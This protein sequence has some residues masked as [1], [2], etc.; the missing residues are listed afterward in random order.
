MKLKTIT[1]LTLA[2]LTANVFA[3]EADKN[4]AKTTLDFRL[5]YENVGQDNPLEDASALTLRTLLNYTS[6]SYS[7]FSGFIEFED[8]R[9]VAGIDDYNDGNGSK[10]DYSVVADP[11]TTELDQGYVK[12]AGSGLTAKVGRQVITFDNHRFVGH[13]GWRQDKQTFDGAT[14]NYKLGKD[15][16]LN[17]A[18]VTQRNRIFGEEKDLKSKDHMLNAS[19]NLGFAKLTGY[20][21]L[22]EV[23]NNTDNSL[24]TFGVR[25]AGS[26][27]VSKLKVS[28]QAEFA[29]QT[30]D[31]AGVEF[32]APYYLLE[33]GAGF[34]GIMAKLG[35]ESLGSDDGLYGFSTPL[36]TLHKF[37]GWSDQ[38]LNTPVQGLNDLYVSLSGKLFEGNW[39][40]IYH[41]FTAAEST[42]LVDDLGNEINAQYTQKFGGRYS[43]GLKFA[44]YSAGDAGAGKV[45]TDKVW[46]WM[47]ARF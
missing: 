38:F 44:M 34:S 7:G 21:Y 15:L 4:E 27:D 41:N 18:Y 35:Y 17:Y 6:K 31:T 32:T 13:V 45:D 43:A 24:N 42:A 29:T 39:A 12:W 1:L 3:E 33:A 47:T 10:P 36:A 25:L 20:G 28:Y 11:E 8:S 9:V 37:N 5:R 19:Y 26:T 16:D 14:F 2:G 46:L 30:S 23:D 40:F 22:L